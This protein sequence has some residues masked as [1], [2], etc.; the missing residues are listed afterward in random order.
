MICKQIETKIKVTFDP[1]YLDVLDESNC[2]TPIIS[3]T[4]FKVVLVSEYF[5]GESMISRHRAIYRVLAEELAGPVY[6]LALHT[7]TVK[8]WTQLEEQDKVLWSPLCRCIR[9]LIT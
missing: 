4:H 7:Y 1:L 9:S 8:E 3:D 5:N 2:H 6:A